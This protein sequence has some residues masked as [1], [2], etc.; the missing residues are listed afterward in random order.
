[1]GRWFVPLLCGALIAPA[2]RAQG[3]TGAAIEGRVRAA[4]GAAIAEAEVLAT[5]ASN[6][7]RWR[8]PTSGAGRYALEHLSVGGPYRIEVHAI[9][10]EPV[11]RDGV[12]LSLGQR[13]RVDFSLRPGVAVLEPITVYA[14]DDPLIN[15]GRTGPSHIVAESTLARL[16]VPGLDLTQVALLSPLVTQGPGGLSV[17]GQS[18]RLTQLQIDGAASS[19]LLGGVG[20]FGSGLFGA[21]TIAVEAV[22]EVQVLAAP[23]DVRFG[24]FSAG[25]VNAVTKSGS[26]RFEGS[27]TGYF[28]SQG[29]QG[30]DPSGSRGGEFKYGEIG[31][32]LGGPIAHDRAAFFLQAGLQHNSGPFETVTIGTDTTDG[33]DSAGIGFRRSSALRFS[34]ILRDT[35]GVDVG[36]PDRYPFKNPAGNAFA[37]IT[38]QLGVNG[39]LELSYDYSHA[40]LDFLFSPGCRVAYE[41]YC[42]T[43]IAQGLPVTAHATHL[44]WT[45]APGRRLANELLL[46]RRWGRQTCTTA[47]NFPSVFAHADAGELQAGAALPCRGDRVEQQISELTDN[48]TL[49]AGAH[50]ITLGTHDELISLPTHENLQY[51]FHAAWH[52]GSLDSL[53]ANMP[54][55]YDAILD[56]PARPPGPLSDLRVQQAGGYIQDQWSVTPKLLATAG[57]RADVPFVSR[58]PTSNPGLQEAFGVDNTRTPSGHLLWSPRLG[59]S[60]D[61]RG[62]GT[63]FLRGGIGLFAGRP[64]YRWFN[65]VYVHTGLDAIEVICDST[66]V[67]AFVPDITRP[68]TAC[69]GSAAA[70]PVAGP[71]SVFDPAF[72]FPRTLKIA[73]GTDHRLPWGLV[74]TVDLLY[75]QG[76]NQLDLRELNLGPPVGASLGEGGRVLYGMIDPGGEVT[77]G[78]LSPAFGRVTQVRNARG[79]RG[80]SLTSQLQKRFAG[81][82]ELSASYTYTNAR[83]LLSASEDGLDANLDVV[84]LNGTLADR[85]LAPSAWTVPHRVTLL[86]T[87]DLPLRFRL[88]LF[89]EGRS[90]GGPYTYIVAGDANADGYGNDAVYVPANATPGGDVALVVRDEMG[91]TSPAPASAYAELDRFIQRESC[92]RTQQ[93]RVMRR[94]SCR[95]PW[96]NFTNARLSKVVRTLGGQSLE[97]TLDVF[98]LLHLLDGDWGVVRGIDDIALLELVGYD[99]VAGRGIYQSR[100]PRPRSADGDASRWRMFL[101]ARYVF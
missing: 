43:S 68:P 63:T 59:V 52:F 33:A 79:D 37:K 94:N 1:M 88:T 80:F 44:A 54:A 17:A 12:F 20:T 41:V 58:S 36:T 91:Q 83:D 24:S 34:Q 4:D 18:A 47:S 28:I 48:L 67:P 10:F 101:G 56:H 14:A 46:A 49:T 45:A 40:G 85:R 66:N 62:D 76:V 92:L 57:L 30:K 75:N 81:G 61:L 9:G 7:E 13:L 15:P 65:E 73:F 70:P 89:Y 23:F 2:L 71:V 53:E 86:A 38:V 27:I 26:N 55:S 22:K 42:L 19:D 82:Q 8:T 64:A 90:S 74:G 3:V 35:Y 31:L 95:N 16:P 29:F 39:R 97:L 78:R 93:G 72:R 69:A 51:F 11:R 50:R 6:G 32:T 98:N 77:P 25:L 60:Y 99:P 96:V 100:S 87:A 5:S 21:R 84:V